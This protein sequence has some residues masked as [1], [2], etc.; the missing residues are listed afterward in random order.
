MYVDWHV[1]III[2][3]SRPFT[4]RTAGLFNFF[5]IQYVQIYAFG[6]EIEIYEQNL[7]KDIRNFLLQLILK[8]LL[9]HLQENSK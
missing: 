7:R 5:R 1:C 3:T 8:T 6:D 2:M 9:I 4:N